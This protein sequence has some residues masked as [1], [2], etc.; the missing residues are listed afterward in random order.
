M[1]SLL[2]SCHFNHLLRGSKRI[3][4]SASRR[5]W[6]E[7]NGGIIG[8]VWEC[9]QFA[10]VPEDVCHCECHL[11][12]L[13]LQW[14]SY[15]SRLRVKWRKARSKQAIRHSKLTSACKNN[16]T[17]HSSS[18][19]KSISSKWNFPKYLSINISQNIQEDQMSTKQQNIFCGDL[20]SWIGLD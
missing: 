10:V 19:I 18:S 9:H 20:L 12:P 11:S 5:K 2:R 8:L 14:F 15:P 16:F 7:S 6:A 17:P 4:S 1:D 13:I 3:W